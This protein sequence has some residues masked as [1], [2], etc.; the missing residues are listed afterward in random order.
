MSIDQPETVDAIGVETSTG[1]VVLT[2]SDHLDWTLPARHV[3]ALQAK[4][5]CYL[6]FIESG[7]LQEV[8]PAGAGKTVRI[9]LITKY[10]VP[11]EMTPL[12]EQARVTLLR[13]GVTFRSRMI[14]E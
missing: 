4:L 3:A 14:G 13:A 11:M 1:D 12:L 8:Y 7:E 5:N 9:D 2:I 6:G 10:P